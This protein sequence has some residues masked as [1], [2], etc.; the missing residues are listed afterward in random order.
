MW[1]VIWTITGKEEQ[2]RQQILKNCDASTY[3]RC[4]IP[5]I[6]RKRREKGAWVM[7][8]ERFAPSYLF[9]ESETIG[10]FAEELPRIAGFTKLLQNDNLFLPLHPREEELL[11]KLIGDGEIITESIG[12]KEGQ[13]VTITQGPLQGLEGMIKHIDRHKRMAV[14]EMEIFGRIVEMKLGLEVL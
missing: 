12:V 10:A 13:Q 5:L 11:T 2:C 9:V 7:K 14:L 3:D 1:Y 6:Q 4:V 8:T